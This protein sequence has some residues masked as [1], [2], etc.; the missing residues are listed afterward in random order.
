M[1]LM[2]NS[3]NNIDFLVKLTRLYTIEALVG[4]GYFIRVAVSP[5]YAEIKEEAIVFSDMIVV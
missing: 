4:S 1:N 2:I 5:K 3:K